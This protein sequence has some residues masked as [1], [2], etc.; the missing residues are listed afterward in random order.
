MDWRENY[1][2]A[3]AK[4]YGSDTISIALHWTEKA[5]PEIARTTK[6][7]GENFIAQTIVKHGSKLRLIKIGTT[8]IYRPPAQTPITRS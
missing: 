4:N 7:E 2:K 8:D 1:K 6:T 3:T 5:M